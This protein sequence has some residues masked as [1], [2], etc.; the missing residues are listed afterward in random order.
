MIYAL[1]IQKFIVRNLPVKYRKPRVIAWLTAWLR[2]FV[3]LHQRFLEFRVATLYEL[4][5]NCTVGAIEKV[6]NDTFDPVERPSF[7]IYITDA[8]S[9]IDRVGLYLLEERQPAQPLYLI[10]EIPPGESLPLGLIEE[11]DGD[12]DFIVHVALSLQ[13][14]PAAITRLRGIVDR[15][16]AAGTTWKIQYY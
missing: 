14:S 8:V 3:Q 4:S 12:V 13:L 5:L 15:Y 7:L 6:L 2:P 11:Y 1:N 16:R 10:S 9:E